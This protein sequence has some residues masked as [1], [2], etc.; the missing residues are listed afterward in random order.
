MTEELDGQMNFFGPDTESTKTCPEHCPPIKEK[1]GSVSL[2]RSAASKTHL[3]MFLDLRGSGRNADQ[4]WETAILSH[5]SVRTLNTGEFRKDENGLLWLPTSTDTQP[6]TFYLTLN[7]GEKPRVPNPTKLSQILERNPDPKYNLS[8]RACQ[9]ILNRAAK[10]GKELPKAL[11]DALEY[12]AAMEPSLSKNEPGNQGGVKDSSS[13]TSE[14]DQSEQAQTKAFGI[15]AYDSNSMKSSNPHSGIYEADTSR[16][17]DNN[18]GSPACNQGGVAIVNGV[19]SKGNGEAFLTGDKH[20]S[21]S[22]GGGQAGQ[23][24]PCVLDGSGCLNPWDVQSKHIQQPNG[25]AE[26]LYSG[27]RR[28][29]GGESYVLDEPQ[30]VCIEGNGQRASH[31]GDGYSVSDASYTLNTVEQ[32]GVFAFTQNQREECRDL[33]D[34]AGG[35]SAEPGSHQQ[36]YVLPF[37]TTQVTSDKNWSKP[38]YGDPC[39]PLASGAHPPSA[40][41]G[42]DLY[43]GAVTGNVAATLGANTGQSGNHTAITVESPD[44][45]KTR[46]TDGGTKAT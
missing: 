28:Y 6:P 21:L 1:T 46:D 35:L 31:Y 11:K 7:I 8:A 24:Y 42:A 33:N 9:G 40:V 22:I 25:V 45:S 17:L 15:S 10:R 19:V 5:G 34:T 18:G 30:T 43:N 44:A 27:E 20:T 14:R 13:K 36:T 4:S 3:P 23:G 29:G 32:H 2:K 26:S 37:D 39:H 16:T 41:I 12:Q 38:K